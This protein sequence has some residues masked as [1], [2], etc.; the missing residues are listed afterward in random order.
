MITKAQLKE[1]SYKQLLDL[2]DKVTNMLAERQE[3]EKAELK[4]Q[5]QDLA[6]SAGFDL[7]DLLGRG[8]GSKRGKVPAKYRNPENPDETWSGRGRQPRWLVAK[9]KKRGTKLES[10]L[11]N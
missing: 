1:L 7:S 6:A 2:Q 4:R 10:F 5:M 11:I 9:L 3:E 8:K